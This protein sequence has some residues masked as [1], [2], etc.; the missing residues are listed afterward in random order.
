MQLSSPRGAR[1]ALVLGVGVASL[2]WAA[3]LIRLTVA[4]AVTV[5]AWR[6]VLSA[7]VL[8]PAIGLRRRLLSRLGLRW[9]LAAG[10]FLA[11]HFVFWIESLRHTTVASS[12]ALVTTNPIFVGILSAV[13]LGERPSRALWEGI[14]LSVA[15]GLLIGWG[16]V[17]LGGAALWGDALALLG[18]VAASAYLLLGRR[19]RGEDLL[20]YVAV[21]YGTAAV[22]LLLAAIVVE[23]GNPLPL[24]GDW[25]WLCLMAAGPQLLGHTSV[26]W[27]LRRFPA[28]VVAVAI[29][30]EPVGA[31]LWAYAVF[32]E[33][34]GL[35]QG[36]GII[37]VLTGIVRALRAVRL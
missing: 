35:V 30:G 11:L 37:L 34:P 9:A 12:V 16:D 26:N 5:A 13:L 20:P 22:L 31:S 32:G 7:V 25:L 2:S 19:A 23:C 33:R 24:P 15:G 4:P 10:A 1:T 29:L 3:I 8:I 6:M 27:A 21:T 18:A 17:V 14:G 36:L 28:S